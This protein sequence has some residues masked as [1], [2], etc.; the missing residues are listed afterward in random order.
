MEKNLLLALLGLVFYVVFKSPSKKPKEP[1]VYDLVNGVPI[2]LRYAPAQL[3]GNTY[4]TETLGWIENSRGNM[5]YEKYPPCF[6]LS[7]QAQTIF[8]LL[9]SKNLIR[10]YKVLLD[11]ISMMLCQIKFLASKVCTS[12]M[13]GERVKDLDAFGY[14]RNDNR[15]LTFLIKMIGQKQYDDSY[16]STVDF[17]LKSVTLIE[18]QLALLKNDVNEIT[19]KRISSLVSEVYSLT[20]IQIAEDC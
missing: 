17:I 11:V 2:P 8:D 16:P 10:K 6:D 14:V 9:E 4:S 7:T 12:T 18:D 19:I 15:Y 13:I 1:F 5:N 3:G 20:L